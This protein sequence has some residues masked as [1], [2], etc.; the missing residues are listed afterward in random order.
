ML[1]NIFIKFIKNQKNPRKI[2][3]NILESLGGEN[4]FIKEKLKNG[5]ADISEE[6][7]KSAISNAY[8]QSAVD[9]F[10]KISLKEKRIIL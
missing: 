2:N 8:G 7:I 3:T 10:T 1:R 5:K 9:L 6:D 4:P